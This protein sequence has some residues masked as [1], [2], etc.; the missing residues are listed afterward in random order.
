MDGLLIPSKKWETFKKL[1][2][3]TIKPTNLANKK[4]T[5]NL[6]KRWKKG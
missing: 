6:R 2:R 3:T 5:K 4:T 1:W